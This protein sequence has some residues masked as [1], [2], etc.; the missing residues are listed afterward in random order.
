MLKQ[1]KKKTDGQLQVFSHNSLLD[2]RDEQNKG[3]IQLLAER[4]S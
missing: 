4:V 3:E 1:H 2:R